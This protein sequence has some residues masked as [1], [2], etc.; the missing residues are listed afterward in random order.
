MTD[1]DPRDLVLTRDLDISPE[2]VWHAWTTPETYGHWFCPKPWETTECEIDLQ[3]GGIFRT[4]MEGPDGERNEGSGCILVAEPNRRLLWTAALGPGY[5]PND[6]SE[7]GFPFSA[8]I[9]LEPIDGG[10]RY[11][12]RAM[13][14][15]AEA[16]ASH[17]EMGFT[18]GWGIVIDQLVAYEKSIAG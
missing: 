7:G 4:V 3:P 13:H 5:T 6:F 11:T 16:A 8:E 17:D 1:I 12:A 2:A 9:T 18:V 10:T 14:P 15:T